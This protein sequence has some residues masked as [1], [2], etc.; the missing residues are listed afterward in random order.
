MGVGC[1]YYIVSFNTVVAKHLKTEIDTLLYYKLLFGYFSFMLGIRDSIHFLK[2][3][4]Q[5][6][7]SIN[8]IWDSKDSVINY[9][10]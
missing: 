8:F 4:M 10:L 9:L 7:L 1:D 5:V 2:R 3:G 6:I